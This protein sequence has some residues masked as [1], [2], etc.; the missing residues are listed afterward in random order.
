MLSHICESLA[1][2]DARLPSMRSRLLG[3]GRVGG[4]VLIG[5]NGDGGEHREDDDRDDE[6]ERGEP[7]WAANRALW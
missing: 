6:F 7:H 3:Q 5:G 1:T 4:A 2:I